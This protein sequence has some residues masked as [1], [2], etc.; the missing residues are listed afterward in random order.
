MFWLRVGRNPLDVDHSELFS[1]ASETCACANLAGR[2]VAAAT[3]GVKLTVVLA[4]H[5]SP[6]AALSLAAHK[7]VCAIRRITAATLTPDL[8]RLFRVGGKSRFFQAAFVLPTNPTA[9]E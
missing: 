8:I 6:S 5:L 7:S 4:F 1:S 3:T 2:C 9:G